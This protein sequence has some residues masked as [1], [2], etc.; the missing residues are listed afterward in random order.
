MREV[1]DMLVVCSWC[2]KY[3]TDKEPLWNKSVSHSICKECY[4][5]FEEKIASSSTISEEKDIN[6]K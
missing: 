6:E 3:I 4:K 2:G 5:S 1:I